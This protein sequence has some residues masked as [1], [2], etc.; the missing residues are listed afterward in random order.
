MKSAAFLLVAL[1]AGAQAQTLTLEAPPQPQNNDN[2]AMSVGVDTMTRYR[3][4]LQVEPELPAPPGLTLVPPSKVGPR[5][6]TFKGPDF[7]DTDSYNHVDFRSDVVR[8]MVPG[9]VAPFASLAREAGRLP[10]DD[11][12]LGAGAGAKWNLSPNAN[13]GTELLVFPASATNL[14]GDALKNADTKLMTR[15]ELKF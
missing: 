11:G 4:D 6:N 10:D 1:A 15:L 14:G 12:R 2:I 5:I 9:R 13:F 3:Q 7:L 8:F